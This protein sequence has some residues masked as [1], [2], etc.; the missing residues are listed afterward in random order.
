MTAAAPASVISGKT[1]AA[2]G[3]PAT[4][5][6]QCSAAQ[7]SAPNPASRP[8]AAGAW[9]LTAYSQASRSQAWPGPADR[10]RCGSRR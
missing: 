5:Q 7:S 8:V 9:R 1:A 6:C 3:P 2:A 10:G 4:F